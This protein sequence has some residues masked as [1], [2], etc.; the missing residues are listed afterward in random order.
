MALDNISAYLREYGTELGNRVLAQFPALHA[1]G[2]LLAKEIQQLKRSPFP[3]QAM[4][5]M[6]IVKRWQEARC[7]AAVAECGTGKTLI[8][9][10]SVFTHAAGRP[11]TALAMVPPQLVEKWA[12]ECFLTIP[13]VRVF[14]IDGVRNGIGSNGHTGVNEV[15]LR[16]GKILREGL[17]TT[18]SEIRLAG[19]HRS[20]RAKWQA[21]VQGPSIFV[22]SRER[23]KLGYFWRHVIRTARS[24][25]FLGNVV[26]PDTGIPVAT[27]DDQLRRADFRKVKHSEVVIP[28]TNRGRRPFFSPLWQADNR[29]IHRMAPIEF[30]GRY[31]RDFFDYGIADEVHELKGETAQ[32]NA[33]GTLASACGHTVILT[34]TLLGGYADELFN[35]LYRLDARAM[36]EDGFDHGESGLRQFAE[37]YGVLEK[38]TT[39]EASENS[40]SKARVSTTVKRRP[41]ASP[42]LFGKYLMNMAAFVSLEDISGALPS[43]LEEVISVEMDPTLRKAY[44]DLES[45]IQGALRDHH[46]NASVISTAM[47]ALLLYPDRPF[48]L[49]AL[50]GHSVNPESGERERF[51]IAEPAD[52]DESVVYAKERRLLTEVKSELAQGRK[53]QIY[54]VYTQKRDV[55]RRLQRILREGGVRAEVLTA[56]TPPE[57]REAWYERQL[58]NGMQVC[59]CHPKLVQTGLDL[60]EFPTILFYE[61]G[62]STY[63]LRQA[64][65]RSWRIGQKHPVRVGFLTYAG[66]AQESCLRLMGKKLLVS[67]AMEGKLQAEGLQKM[68]EDDDVLTAMARELVT[69]QGVGE[70]AAEV[71]RSLQTQAPQQ[72]APKPAAIVVDV[73]PEPELPIAVMGPAVQL[74]LF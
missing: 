35:I 63:V 23:A 51:L 64:S 67:L 11:F 61:T 36:R 47:N 60:L 5:I 17:R 42:L 24:G 39:I 16:N 40:C 22:F 46:G 54:A 56:D 19:K 55:T 69:R 34:G 28:E 41:G 18:L 48:G 31:M 1:P 49:G 73:M 25:P 20:A 59:I 6:G 27:S 10:G 37:A 12:R 68:D 14:I 32:G 38:V 72:Q 33:L 15:R 62:Y 52:L 4:A 65:R 45:D 21:L 66:T 3:A 7:A 29:K 30:I 9:L 26:N 43:Y 58:K 44:S 50:Y 70:Q 57:Q 74:S 71:W 2:D 53:V 13:G 8:S